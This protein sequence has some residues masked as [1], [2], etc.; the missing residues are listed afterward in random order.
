MNRE[1]NEIESVLESFLGKSKNGMSDS[2]ELEFGCPRC[3]EMYGSGELLKYNLAV[4]VGK[5]V[6]KCW[7]CESDG[8]DMH[9]AISKLVRL[10]G[11]E[12][13]LHRYNEAL[14]SMVESKYYQLHLNDNENIDFKILKKTQ[15]EFPKNYIKLYKDSYVPRRVADY[16]KKRGLGWDIV[17]SHDIG[18]TLY[19]ENDKKMSNRIIIPSYN[20]N[21]EL[22]YWTGRDFTG[23]PKRQK[24]C[25]PKV[26]RKDII[27]NENKIQWDA[28]ITIVEG[29][30][31]HIVVPNSVPLLGKVVKKGFRLYDM[32]VA[33]AKADINIFLDGDAVNTAIGLYKLLNHGDLYGRI[34]IVPALPDED[35][36]SIYEKEGK[37][38]IIHHLSA[39]RKIHDVYLF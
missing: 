34:N 32:L 27:F 29:P 14:R 18:Y 1:L 21:G 24:Y 16:L 12:N 13:A 33:Q 17:S 38:G 19:D 28:D 36:S 37:E 11:G 10:Y 23:N 30:F 6:F 7:K 22:N 3:C 25:N 20:A 31:D 15:L 5:G 4:N 26:E 2:F 9:G 35:P 8:D 39:T